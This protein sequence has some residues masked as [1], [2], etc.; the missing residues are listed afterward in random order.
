MGKATFG[1]SLDGKNFEDFGNMLPL[2][3]QLYTFQGPRYSL[4][5]YNK[6][7]QRGG[8]V[9]FDNFKT[10]E[11][12]PRGLR[13][14][15]PYGQ[16]IQLSSC[17]LNTTL[18]IGGCQDWYVEQL[19][20]GRVA[21]KSVDGQ[22]MSV[23]HGQN[24]RV[25]LVKKAK[26]EEAE[27]FQWMELE[28]GDLVLMSLASNRYLTYYDKDKVTASTSTPLPNRNRDYTRMSWSK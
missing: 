7:G 23:D 22:Y 18:I 28:G 24:D 12:Y 25:S 17:K 14:D 2:H 19:P 1:Y 21:L 15:I 3:F 10:N 6:L 5:A 9:D 16:T 4:F 13:R 8:Y 11:K 20:L 26:P 27:S